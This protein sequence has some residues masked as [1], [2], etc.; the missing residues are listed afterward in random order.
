M[1]LFQMQMDSG[2]VEAFLQDYLSLIAVSLLESCVYMG[3][4][5]LLCRFAG[6]VG[7]VSSDF[8]YEPMLRVHL[9]TSGCVS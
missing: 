2:V 3:L 9:V 6:L 8:R 5:V 7:A 1:K 4:V